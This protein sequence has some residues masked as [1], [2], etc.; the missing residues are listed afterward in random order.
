MRIGS[1]S[2]KIL[3]VIEFC[4][5]KYYMTYL[6]DGNLVGKQDTELPLV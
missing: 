2:G 3:P 5:G 4:D 1:P 6:K